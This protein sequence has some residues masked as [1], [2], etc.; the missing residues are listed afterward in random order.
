VITHCRLSCEKP[1]SVL[2]DGKATFTIEMSS[3]TMNC[4][5]TIKEGSQSAY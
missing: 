4:A 5:V 2:I 3:T 1:K